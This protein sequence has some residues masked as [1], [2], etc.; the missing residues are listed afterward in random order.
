VSIHPTAIVES[1]AQLG[2][3]VEIG[4]YVFVGSE[5]TI[6][7]D[8][9]VQSHA[10][11]KGSVRLGARNLIGHGS[12][13]G[14]PP[15]DLGFKPEMRSRVEIG[16]D[17]VIREHCTIHRGAEEDS[18]T[19]VGRGNFFMVGVHVAHNCRVGDNIIIANNCLLGGYVRIDDGAFLGG[20]SA[21][22]QHSHIGRL[23]MCQGN[24]AFSKNV[25]PFLLA[26]ERNSCF[27][28]NHIGLR[29][30]GF[31]AAQRDEIRRAFKLLY[32]SG[33][34]IHQAL[35]RADATELGPEAR[36]L[37]EF[38]REAGKRGIVP[39]R[40]AHQMIDD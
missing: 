5:V 40:R 16:E 4:P 27:G 8:T 26:G 37:F 11:L 1:G 15:Q 10:I 18:A 13:I 14:G 6:G 23:A 2:E 3:R 17:N 25:P 19:I 28:V 38:V 22:H 34:N 35:E 24:S 7:D 32:R 12:V 39:C 29:R 31:S 33:L 9:A 30:A 20:A 21:F 36:E